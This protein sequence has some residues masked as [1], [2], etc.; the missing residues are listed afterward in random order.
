MIS[1][2]GDPG[3]HANLAA[4]PAAGANLRM[5]AL[6][7]KGGVAAATGA[8]RQ[9][10]NDVLRLF[11][12]DAWKAVLRSIKSVKDAVEIMISMGQTQTPCENFAQI[13]E[14]LSKLVPLE[15]S[16]Q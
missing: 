4:P 7:D 14:A 2:I 9:R 12:A 1:E 8:V 5:K 15:T 10:L 6:F 16:G 11:Q 13:N 3:D